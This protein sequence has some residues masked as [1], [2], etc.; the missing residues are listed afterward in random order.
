MRTAA[1]ANTCINAG[2][3]FGVIKSEALACDAIANSSGLTPIG[4]PRS[5]LGQYNTSGT[6]SS[7]FS[8][9]FAAGFDFMSS[10]CRHSPVTP[11]EATPVT[12][13]T[14]VPVRLQ[15]RSSTPASPQ[16]FHSRRLRGSPRCRFSRKSAVADWQT[17][18]KYFKHQRL[19]EHDWRISIRDAMA[20]LPS[21]CARHSSRC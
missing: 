3:A 8:I 19:E 14:G 17:P 11:P 7:N 6:K 16:P 9:M 15:T 13:L 21:L 4:R 1:E 10:D 18:S 5:A 2:S 12:I 20:F